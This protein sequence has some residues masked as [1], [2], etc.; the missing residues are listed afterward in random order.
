MRQPTRLAAVIFLAL[1]ASVLSGCTN[2][3]LTQPRD[4]YSALVD[5]LSQL[6]NPASAEFVDKKITPLI[7]VRGSGTHVY[8]IARPAD[9]AAQIQF[10]VSCTP[11]VDFTV[12]MGRS[13]S[14]GCVATTGD[15]GAIPV[16]FSPG[17]GP[18]QVTV[19][20]PGSTRYW[21]VGIPYPVQ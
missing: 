1:A 6:T 19:K 15:S 14:S 17:T 5:P 10:F 16:T 2:V 12:T 3:A 8:F 18:L 21:L 9:P 7:H 13:F 4:A 20:V 11:G